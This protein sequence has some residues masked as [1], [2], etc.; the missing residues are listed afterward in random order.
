M[1][2][3]FLL[4]LLDGHTPVPFPDDE[5][6]GRKEVWMGVTRDLAVEERA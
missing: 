3:L 5:A 4:V 2:S 1:A 6:V